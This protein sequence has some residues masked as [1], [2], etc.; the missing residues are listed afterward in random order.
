MLDEKNYFKAVIASNNTNNYYWSDE[1]SISFYIKL[2]KLGFISTSYDT[3]EG[4]VLLPELQYE[5]AL[6]DFEDLHISKKVKK[7]MLQDKYELR[8]NTRFDEVLQALDNQHKYN[9]LKGEYAELM[10]EIYKKDFDDFKLVSVE[11]VSKKDN[12]LIAGEIGYIIS[13]TYTSLSGFSLKEKEYNN[14]GKLQLTLLAKQLQKDG[15]A[16]WNLGHPHM[17]YKQKLGAKTYPRSEFLKRYN[18]V[19]DNN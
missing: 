18:S 16:F 5:Y 10:R 2:A 11:L 7:L 8:F 6:L 17:I 19:I 13:K 4:L 1:F 14:C 9:W 15:F 3:K 12:K